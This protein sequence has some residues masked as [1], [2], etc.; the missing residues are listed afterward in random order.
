MAVP[1]WSRTLMQTQRCRSRTTL[2]VMVG[3]A[4]PEGVGCLPVSF[5][6]L[7]RCDE[8]RE[9]DCDVSESRSQVDVGGQSVGE[10]QE[11]D[12]PSDVLRGAKERER[13]RFGL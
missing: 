1:V 13:E 5:G 4:P 3:A 11:G 9:V 10:G 7:T 2:L 12:G 8:F 6:A